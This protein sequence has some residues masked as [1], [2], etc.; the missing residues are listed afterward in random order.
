MNDYDFWLSLDESVKTELEAVGDP[1][2]R[3]RLARVEQLKH[4]ALGFREAELLRDRRYARALGSEDFEEEL[5]GSTGR[6]SGI[7][8]ES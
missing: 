3:D 1:T 6:P 5:P 4:L 7:H 2:H 8:D